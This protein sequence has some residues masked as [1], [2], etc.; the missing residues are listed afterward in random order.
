MD[1]E[2]DKEALQAERKKKI[3]YVSKS[4]IHKGHPA[5]SQTQSLSVMGILKGTQEARVRG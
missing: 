1:E 4:Q 5:H 3:Q 2:E